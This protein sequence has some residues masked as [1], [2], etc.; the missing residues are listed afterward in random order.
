MMEQ[1]KIDPNSDDCLSQLMDSPL[2]T[3]IPEPTTD[4]LPSGFLQN[5]NTETFFMNE[6][7]KEALRAFC[8]YMNEQS[9][10]LGMENS[11]WAVVHGMFHPRNFSSAFDIAKLT[12]ISLQRHKILAEVVNVKSLMTQSKNQAG[13]VYKWE[14]TNKLLWDTSGRYG[15]SAFF[16]V[17]TG[18]T[19]SAG[20][21]LSV[22][23][24]DQGFEFIVVVL[25]C[26]THDARFVEVPILT[27]WALVKLLR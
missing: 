23:Y 3:E 15:T 7:I 27:R 25:N 4:D 1:A 16:G 5:F 11:S 18:T 10:K 14:N 8:G 17:K 26:E 24:R 2:R 21:C 9:R 22:I 20:P 6:K 13:H 12:Q 19:P